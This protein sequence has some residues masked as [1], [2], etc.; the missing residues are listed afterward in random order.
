[1][2]NT[3][4]QEQKNLDSCPVQPFASSVAL[5]HLVYII[6]FSKPHFHHRQNESDTMY[7]VSRTVMLSHKQPKEFNKNIKK[8]LSV[9]VIKCIDFLR[10]LIINTADY[11]D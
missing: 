6:F 5:T 11:V 7:H 2:A 10:L 4:H 8:L 9:M 3:R 1:M